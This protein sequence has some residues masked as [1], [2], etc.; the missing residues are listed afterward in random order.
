MGVEGSCSCCRTAA[1]SSLSTPDLRPSTAA[2]AAAT[3]GASNVTVT[4][5]SSVVNPQQV[6]QEI[7]DYLRA[8]HLGGGD[9]RYYTAV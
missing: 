3:G 9:Q 5:N 2:A 8:Y 7:A 4:V 6:G 1:A